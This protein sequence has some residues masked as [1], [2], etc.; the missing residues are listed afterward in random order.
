MCTTNNLKISC[1]TNVPATGADVALKRSD[2]VDY[3]MRVA[4]GG[5]LYLCVE[6]TS[7][8]DCFGRKLQ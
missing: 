2:G 5:T 1:I 6:P 3:K 4:K 8:T 7:L